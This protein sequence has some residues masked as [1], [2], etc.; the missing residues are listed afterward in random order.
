MGPINAWVVASGASVPLLALKQH[1]HA[2]WLAN[3]F[4]HASL[5]KSASRPAKTVKASCDDS[6]PKLVHAHD[7]DGGLLRREGF[8]AVLR[9]STEPRSE[10]FYVRLMSA[11]LVA[12]QTW[13]AS[14]HPGVTLD[15]LSNRSVVACDA[16]F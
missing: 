16:S 8:I 3:Y 5:Q 13:I 15:Q 6:S 1:A 12:S 2:L 4:D 7:V 9:S 11:R 14:G 10:E